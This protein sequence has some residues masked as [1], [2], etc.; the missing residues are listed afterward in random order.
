MLGLAHVK[1]WFRP[2]V[3]LVILA[4]GMPLSLSSWMALL[5]NFAIENVGFDGF[6]IGVLQSLR[7]IPGL[8]SIG[9]VLLLLF[10]REQ[11]LV[12]FFLIWN[13]HLK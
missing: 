13:I 3:F 12:L 2:E 8:L 5:N 10:L 4:I 6:R 1:K 7:E 9:V 11:S